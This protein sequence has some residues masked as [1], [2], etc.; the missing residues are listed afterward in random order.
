MYS[1]D[2]V[3]K[4]QWV[5]VFDQDTVKSVTCVANNPPAEILHTCSLECKTGYQLKK[6]RSNNGNPLIC[7]PS[8]H[9]QTLKSKFNQRCVKKP[10]H[11]GC[12]GKICKI[13]SISGLQWFKVGLSG[14][15][16]SAEN[17]HGAFIYNIT[18][19]NPLVGEG[20]DERG[21]VILSAGDDGYFMK[22][23]W[24][25]GDFAN[26][27]FTK[28][29]QWEGKITQWWWEDG[30]EVDFFGTLKPRP[31]GDKRVPYYMTWGHYDKYGY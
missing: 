19:R 18:S 17:F 21:D 31:D 16:V 25:N 26:I 3:P 4:H 9:F 10:R 2:K 5:D 24:K 6:S 14:G 22:K 27:N 30:K 12:R 29:R 8:M 7:K 1:C 15:G 28:A 23:T 13:G 11:D 20:R